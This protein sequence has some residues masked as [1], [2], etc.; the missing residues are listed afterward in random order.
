[1][2]LLK[3]KILQQLQKIHIHK[4]HLMCSIW[5]SI[6]FLASTACMIVVFS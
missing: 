1:M 5:T 2:I 4:Q 6:G 3:T